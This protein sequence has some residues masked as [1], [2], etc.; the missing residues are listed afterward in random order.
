M[1]QKDLLQLTHFGIL[2]HHFALIQF[3]ICVQ[4]LIT[5]STNNTLLSDRHS[6]Q[7]RAFDQVTEEMF[8]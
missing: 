2:T 1:E 7:A 8:I 3:L 4:A 5:F 6:I